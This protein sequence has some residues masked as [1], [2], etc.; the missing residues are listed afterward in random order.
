[1]MLPLFCSY[2]W[3]SAARVVTA[4]LGIPLIVVLGHA[5]CGAVSACDV[6]TKRAQFPGSIGPMARA[7]LPAVM[8]V[9]SQPAIS[10]TTRVRESAKRTA[11]RGSRITEERQWP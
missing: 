1:M 9:K 10:L 4:V 6:V 3:R 2:I 5:R 8:A 7:I 11:V